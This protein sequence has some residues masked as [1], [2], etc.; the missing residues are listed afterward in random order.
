VVRERDTQNLRVSR[1][2]Q[3]LTAAV[4]LW[5]RNEKSHAG[6]AEAVIASLTFCDPAFATLDREDLNRALA[7]T[8]P[9][10]LLIK[11]GRGK[12]GALSLAAELA[13]KVNAFGHRIHAN[14]SPERARRRVKNDLLNAAKRAP[15]EPPK[16]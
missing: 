4:E 7:A 14:E 12:A 5:H 15:R 8:K 6:I 9:K 11:G 1:C 16:P 2:V 10:E 3:I 13:L